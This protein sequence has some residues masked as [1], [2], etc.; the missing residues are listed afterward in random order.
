MKL[1]NLI[2][3]LFIA[4]F[5]A[6]TAGSSEK[7]QENIK[8]E[9]FTN[10]EIGWRVTMPEGYQLTHQKKID[11]DEQ[12][13][14]EAVGKVYDG[15]LKDSKLKHVFSFIRNQFNSFNSTI[16]PYTEKYKGE[17]L[18]NGV[19]V[20]RLLY[21][22][23]HKQGIKIDTSSNE[24]IV[25]GEKFN[26]FYLKIYGPTGDV[27]LNQ[28]LFNKMIKGYDFGVSIN[29]NNEEDRAKLLQTFMNSTFSKN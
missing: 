12:R 28:I 9:V 5:S 24:V 2:L 20:K 3:F 27:V 7:R 22:T 15:Q 29:Y 6:C 11:T 25:D 4:T 17:Y 23:Y 18:T 14:K 1:Y 21:D 13:G 8:P 19:L 10:E 16:E 26:A